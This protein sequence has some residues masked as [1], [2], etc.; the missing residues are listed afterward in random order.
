LVVARITA[1]IDRLG[2]DRNEQRIEIIDAAI[3]T[4]PELS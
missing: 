2:M 4:A 1:M 3:I